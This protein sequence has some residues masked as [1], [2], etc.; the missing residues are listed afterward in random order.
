MTPQELK[1]MGEM[2]RDALRDALAPVQKDI[3]G[4][5]V[6]IGGLETNARDAK[7]DI[8]LLQDTDRKHSKEHRAVTGEILPRMKSDADLTRERDL[9]ATATAYERMLRLHDDL[10]QRMGGMESEI[11]SYRKEAA[12]RAKKASFE[13]PDGKGNVSI[14]PAA[15][16]AAQAAY[17]NEGTTAAIAVDTSAT[18]TLAR[19]NLKW[20]KRMAILAGLAAFLEALRHVITALH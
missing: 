9:T 2:M 3:E 1:L 13:V 11:A 5:K 4:I 6:R 17:R 20:Q 16:V 15:I 19:S 12:E 10:A 18:A 8:Q 14:V 7:R